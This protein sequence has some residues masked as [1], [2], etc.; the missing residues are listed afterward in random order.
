MTSSGRRNAA[1]LNGG[2]TEPAPAT[3]PAFDETLGQLEATVAA[4][5]G[6]QLPLDEALA[7]FERGMR[8]AQTCERVLDAA[9]LRIQQLVAE[10]DDSGEIVARAQ[11]FDLE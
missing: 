6:G 5:E 4:L 9:E 8:L 1:R 3:L 7:I 2:K 11:D 10:E